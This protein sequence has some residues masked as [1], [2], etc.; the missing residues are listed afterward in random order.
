MKANGEGIWEKSMYLSPGEYEYKFLV[1]GS[2]V[3][4]P[5]NDKQSLNCF[6]TLNSVIQIPG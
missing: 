4:D 1:D 5:R 3:E 6:G 2:W